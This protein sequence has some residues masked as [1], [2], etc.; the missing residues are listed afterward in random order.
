MESRYGSTNRAR[1]RLTVENSQRETPGSPPIGSRY[2]RQQTPT[3]LPDLAFRCADRC[4][5]DVGYLPHRVPGRPN[6]AVPYLEGDTG[7]LAIGIIGCLRVGY[8]ELLLVVVGD[9]LIGE[10]G[11]RCCHEGRRSGKRTRLV[12]QR[13][14]W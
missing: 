7:Q 1:S 6:A 14:M 4:A 3:Q 5:T 13:A 8:V 9:L 11:Q 12:D 10:G 2:L